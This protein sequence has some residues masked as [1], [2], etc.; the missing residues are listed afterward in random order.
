MNNHV[1]IENDEITVP[2][3][4][5]HKDGE[6]RGFFGPFRFLSNFYILSNGVGFEELCYPSVEH[7]YQAAKWPRHQRSQFLDVTAAQAKR[8]GKE[9]PALNVKK[10]NKNKAE[11][12]RCLVYQKFDQNVP[13]RKLLVDM[14]GYVLDERNSWGDVYWG[15]NIQGEGENVLGKILMGVRDKF[16]ELASK[17]KYW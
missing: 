1:N 7:A 14:D 4:A 10:W 16:I 17:E 8:L 12:M 5:I 13:L 2:H 3:Y 9:A 6:I 11:L 15:T